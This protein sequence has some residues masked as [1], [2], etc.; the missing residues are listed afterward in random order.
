MLDFKAL[1]SSVAREDEA[2][3]CRRHRDLKAEP[4]RIRRASEAVEEQFSFF[5]QFEEGGCVDVE[6][7]PGGKEGREGIMI[8]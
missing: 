2:S 3:G 6:Q 7:I 5:L 8:V 1:V 4:S